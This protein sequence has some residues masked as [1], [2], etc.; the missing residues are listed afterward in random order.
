MPFQYRRALTVDYTKVSAATHSNFAVLVSITLADLKTTANGGKVTS[1]NGYDIGF[2]AEAS[3]A[4]KLTWEVERYVATTGELVAWVR[5]P[6][7]S[8]T[9]NTVFHLFYGDS[10]ITTDQ[11]SGSAVWDANY[12][13]VYHFGSAT[14]LALA[15]ATA[16]ANTLTNNGATAATGAVNGA[17]SFSASS[18]SR[19]QSASLD[20]LVTNNKVTLSFWVKSGNTSQTNKYVVDYRRNTWAVIYGYIANTYEIFWKD[21]A[22]RR[23]IKS[24]V[25]D[26]NWHKIDISFDGAAN[27]L[28]MYYDGVETYNATET[29]DLAN[30]GSTEGL[31]LGTSVGGDNWTGSVD[32]VRASNTSRSTGW[33]V[34]E[35][36]N[37]NS[38]STFLSV[39]TEVVVRTFQY[40]RALTVD[41]TKVS[42]TTHSDFAALVSLTLADLKTTANGGKVTNAS[43][44]D[45]GF[46]SDTTASTKLDWEIERYVPTTGELVAWV[47][48]PSLS[49]T[50][51]T[52][53]YMFYGDSTVTTDQSNKTG[54]WDA[55]T[56]SV[57]HLPNG[58]TLAL[59]DSTSTAATLTNTGSV[60]AAAGQ[61]DGAA[62]FS[63]SNYLATSQSSPYNVTNLTLSAWIKTSITNYGNIIDRDGLSTARQFQFR[64]RNDGKLEAILFFGGNPQFCNSAASINDN[65]WKHVAVTY[66]GTTIRTYVNG[67]ADGTTA[68]SGTLDTGSTVP[69]NIG[70]VAFG[71]NYFIGTIDEPKFVSSVRSAGWIATEY[72]N[73]NSPSTFMSVGTEVSVYYEKTHTSNALL[74]ATLTKTQSSNALLRATLTQT[75]ATNSLLFAR[76]TQQHSS[77]ALLFKQSTLTQTA[78][79][80]LRA[81]FFRE[82]TTS[83][84]LIPLAKDY[85]RQAAAALPSSD[86][87]LSTDYS[88]SD[89]TGVAIQDGTRVDQTGSSYVIHQFRR[90]LGSQIPATVTWVGRSNIAASTLAI[91]LQVY[92]RNTSSWET[93]ASETAAAANTDITLTGSVSSNLGNYYD[94]SYW[95]SFRV[96]QEAA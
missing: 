3:G 73:Q 41:Y 74:R 21:G 29:V 64:V 53:F 37:Q 88:A 96:Y 93:L 56:K 62:S 35:Y 34:T 78:N 77:N 40:R 42:G 79:A 55:S 91:R 87:P 51:N 76:L 95:L 6:S 89:Y 32:E 90:Q 70:R 22:I 28:K 11:S 83:A 81:Q 9:V 82:Q 4:T 14:T 60:A 63:G 85:T 61:V 10:S 66:D 33:L 49:N 52:V 45:I 12:A 2:Y 15:D 69:L 84:R 20:T 18:V 8:N 39:G 36:N 25:A 57:W 13:A 7:L 23:T 38:P 43:G 67:A 5:V 54:V 72:N 58:T 86:T 94:A 17:V 30:I 26:T 50:V 80:L 68:I 75:H 31:Y 16:N 24:G 47:R 92:N 44:F 19:A 1:A 27:T 48:I 65:S 46:Y 71:G 59:T